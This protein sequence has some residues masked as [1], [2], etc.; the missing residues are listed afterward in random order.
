MLPEIINILLF[1]CLYH[2]QMGTFYNTLKFLWYILDRFTKRK[3]QYQTV[4]LL[5]DG[6]EVSSV[7]TF[8]LL[9]IL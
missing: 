1:T 4:I 8:E 5:V 9:H 3:D 6:T 2:R 7:G